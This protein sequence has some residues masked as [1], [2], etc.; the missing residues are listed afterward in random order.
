M[1]AGTDALVRG[2]GILPDLLQLLLQADRAE[3][4]VDAFDAE[5]RK[6]GAFE[7][8]GA[9]VA[10][11]V[12]ADHAAA[13]ESADLEHFQLE[14]VVVSGLGG[15]EDGF[16]PA[17]VSAS[18][19]CEGGDQRFVCRHHVFVVLQPRLVDGLRCLGRGYADDQVALVR[20]TPGVKTGGVDMCVFPAGLLARRS[21]SLSRRPLERRSSSVAN[22]RSLRLFPFSDEPHECHSRQPAVHMRDGIT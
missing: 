3:G 4:A 13:L 22:D 8:G 9:D 6:H 10:Q 20:I 1:P 14:F 11:L 2:F 17:A 5:I 18:A 12:S 15:E 16:G 7:G 21:R 19:G